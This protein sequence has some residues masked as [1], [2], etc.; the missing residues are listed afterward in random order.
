MKNCNCRDLW[1]TR[2]RCGHD[3]TKV[4]GL[5]ALTLV[6]S[7]ALTASAWAQALN[8]TFETEGNAYSQP[9]LGDDW[10]SLYY[11]DSHGLPLSSLNLDLDVYT[12]VIGDFGANDTTRFGE[13]TK[14][15]Q[16]IPDWAWQALPPKQSRT[17]KPSLWSAVRQP[18]K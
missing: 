16:D 7:I 3:L 6:A 12:G 4:L 5:L 8:T 10:D 9:T 14:D 15:I 2:L 17:S 18:A 11:Y 13:G 1:R